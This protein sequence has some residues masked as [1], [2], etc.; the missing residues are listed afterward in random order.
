LTEQGFENIIKTN[1]EVQISGAKP[2]FRGGYTANPEQMAPWP[3]CF[4][5]RVLKKNFK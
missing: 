3:Y 1:G 4:C 5:F 2:R